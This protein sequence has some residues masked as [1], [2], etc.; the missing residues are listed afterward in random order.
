M[1]VNDIKIPTMYTKRR[2]IVNPTSYTFQLAGIIRDHVLLY[3]R[4]SKTIKQSVI[5]FHTGMMV[6]S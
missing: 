2:F 4:M 1:C 5:I 6:A 3:E